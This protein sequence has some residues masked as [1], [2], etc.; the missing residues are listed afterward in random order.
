MQQVNDQNY[1]LWFNDFALSQKRTAN[2]L[3]S[4]CYEKFLKHFAGG[5]FL[6]NRRR[7]NNS[8]AK[9]YHPLLEQPRPLTKARDHGGFRGRNQLEQNVCG[10]NW[11]EQ[12]QREE[13]SF[14]PFATLALAER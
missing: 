13:A 5:H 10:A 9:R 14:N 3:A 2:A 6:F 8:A 7:D 1:T 4:D 11:E 12:T